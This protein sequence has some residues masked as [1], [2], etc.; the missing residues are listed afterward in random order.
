M[1]TELIISMG[2]VGVMLSMLG[3]GLLIAY[4]GS[5]KT[6]NVGFTFLIVGAGLAYYLA[7]IGMDAYPNQSF[8]NGMLAFVGGMIGGIIGIIVFLIAI[9]KS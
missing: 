4:Y 5:S 9:I 2:L 1:N 3:M 6:R 7:E 8:M